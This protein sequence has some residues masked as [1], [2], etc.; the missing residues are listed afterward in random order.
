M[1]S[2][3]SDDDGFDILADAPCDDEDVS[4]H[5]LIFECS[6]QPFLPIYFLQLDGHRQ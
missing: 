4:C 2:G 6:R 5:H 3:I 1:C